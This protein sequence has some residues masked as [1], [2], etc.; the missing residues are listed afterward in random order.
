[1]AKTTHT[2][3]GDAKLIY[4]LSE[5]IVKAQKP[6]R[7]LDAIK[8]D[9][10]VETEFFAKKA[11]VL[12][13]VNA[14]FYQ[15]NPLGFD[16]ALL[17]QEFYAIERD[18]KRLLGQYNEVGGIMLRMCREYRMVLR[19]LDARGTDEFSLISQEL[20]GSA[21]DAFYA[22]GPNVNELAQTLDDVIENLHLKTV[23][24][25]DV[26]R[27]DAKYAV[28]FLQTELDH[29]FQHSKK[30]VEVTL[31]D[32][33]ISDASA[34][35]DRIRIRRD[36]TFSDRDLKLL[37]VHEGWV[38]IGTTMNGRQQP[39]CTFLS[40]GPPSSTVT[41]EGLAVIMEL[42]TFASF[43]ARL[44]RIINRIHTVSMVE[45]GA[46]FLDVYGYYLEFGMNPKEAYSNTVRTFRGSCPDGKPFTKDLAYGKGFILIYNYVRL[47]IR[48]GLVER[49]PLLFLGK[50]TLEDVAIY[51]TLL[52]Q[53]LLVP[54]QFVPEQ[55]RD[56][57]ALSAWMSFS[58]FLNKI[59]VDRLV[60]DYQHFL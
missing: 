29:Y 34:G 41:Q 48:A 33:I 10:Q 14:D 27:H 59:N 28:K 42:F 40:K 20:Y 11:K 56:I 38:H 12:P 58:L 26:K 21:K 19:L 5:R 46:D 55:F 37:L 35:A 23:G 52:E 9:E 22:N 16:P 39:V 4:E 36:A 7:I 17:R 3:T 1:M 50:T 15:R 2:L 25:M 44:A 47:A 18:I 60:Q 43:P 51:Q 54:P 57:A 30:T 24:E 53:K 8:W 31:S 45:D 6:I 13:A 49:I 32:G